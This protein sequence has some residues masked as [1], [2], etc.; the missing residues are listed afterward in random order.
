MRFNTEL[1]FPA[2]TGQIALVGKLVP[3]QHLPFIICPW[4]YLGWELK[5]R[6]HRKGAK[7]KAF[8]FIT[9]KSQNK[10]WSRA[11]GPLSLFTCLLGCK[12]GMQQRSI[13]INC[14]TKAWFTPTRS[15]TG[16]SSV[17]RK[18]RN[19]PPPSS[20]GCS[21]CRQTQQTLLMNLYM[22]SFVWWALMNSL[23]NFTVLLIN[24]KIKF[25]WF[26]R[27]YS[28]AMKVQLLWDHKGIMKPF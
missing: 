1:Y 15:P 17:K 26:D 5:L 9:G 7:W 11:L 8:G 23:I 14:I 18:G 24:N 3:S 13:R 22:T 25:F 28:I 16:F 6:R 2:A 21:C 19:S 4:A 20:L 10:C 12:I 27:L